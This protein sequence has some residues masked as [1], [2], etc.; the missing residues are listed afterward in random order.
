MTLYICFTQIWVVSQNTLKIHGRLLWHI[1]VMTGDFIL[2]TGHDRRLYT[3][4]PQL[5]VVPQNTLK[6]H[7]RILWHI[8]ITTGGF[9][10]GTGHDRRLYTRLTQLY[11]VPQNTL[12]IHGRILWHIPITTDDF[13]NVSHNYWGSGRPA[14]VSDMTT[15]AVRCPP[16]GLWIRLHLGSRSD[17]IQSFNQ[18]QRNIWLYSTR[19]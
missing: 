11:E 19:L 8:P 2:G 10:L 16:S 6:I 15:T 5:C 3:R 12:K 18:Y 9:I 13:T 17:L 4:L 1:P 7:G 14:S